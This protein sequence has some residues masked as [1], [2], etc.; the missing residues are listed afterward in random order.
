MHRMSRSWCDPW[1]HCL[2]LA[3]CGHGI[4]G[5]ANATEDFTE[6]QATHLSYD[7]CDTSRGHGTDPWGLLWLDFGLGGACEFCLAADATGELWFWHREDAVLCRHGWSLVEFDHHLANTPMLGGGWGHS[8]LR[9]GSME[10]GEVQLAQISQCCGLGVP[11]AL[12]QHLH[13][14]HTTH[15][16]QEQPQRLTDNGI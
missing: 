13:V 6:L 14:S 1:C 15:P 7:Y 5:L 10:K 16:L 2:D 11:G 3:A 8:G 9:I 4:F 12:P